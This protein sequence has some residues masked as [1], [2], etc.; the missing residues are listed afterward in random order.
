[1]VSE[2]MEEAARLLGQSRT[3][4]VVQSIQGDVVVQLELMLEALNKEIENKEK[5]L[6]EENKPRSGSGSGSGSGLGGE[7]KDGGSGTLIPPV[8][9]PQVLMMKNMQLEINKKTRKL[10]AIME[11]AKDPGARLMLKGLCLRLAAREAQLADLI[12]Q[13]LDRIEER[14]AEK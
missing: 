7:G 11:T 2:D 10:A 4:M 6:E 8:T 12:K 1:M 14:K 9:L 5:E 3:G 13:I